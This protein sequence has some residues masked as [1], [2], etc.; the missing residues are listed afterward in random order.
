MEAVTGDAMATEPVAEAVVDV[1]GVL[2]PAVG[3]VLASG[4][5]V[6]VPL[7]VALT[8]FELNAFAAHPRVLSRRTAVTH[9]SAAWNICWFFEKVA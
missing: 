1:A 8:T 9:A 6:V 3:V 5:F 2:D 4:I 7:V